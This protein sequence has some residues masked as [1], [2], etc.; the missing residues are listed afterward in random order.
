MKENRWAFLPFQKNRSST[1]IKQT[2]QPNSKTFPSFPS[3]SHRESNQ[4]NKEHPNPNKFTNQNAFQINLIRSKHQKEG[5]ELIP[6]R[7]AHRLGKTNVAGSWPACRAAKA[8]WQHCRRRYTWCD[9]LRRGAQRQISSSSPWK[10]EPQTLQK[11]AFLS[12]IG[13]GCGSCNVLVR[14]L[15]TEVG[16]V[17]D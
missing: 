10:S 2:Q 13:L 6:A 3:F 4:N 1:Q 11:R 14:F 16:K 7:D 15:W 9:Q 17:G 12:G 8:S 5:R